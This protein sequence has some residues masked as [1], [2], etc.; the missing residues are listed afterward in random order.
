MGKGGGKRSGGR[1]MGGSGRKGE[2]SRRE[3]REPLFMDPRY[4]PAVASF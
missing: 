4:A 2:T 1:G 3:G